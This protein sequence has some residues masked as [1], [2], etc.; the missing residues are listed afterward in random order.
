MIRWEERDSGLPSW[1]ELFQVVP[2]VWGANYSR[3]RTHLN[4]QQLGLF[5]A[6]GH[7]HGACALW[8]PKAI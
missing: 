5:Y 3:R 2:M 8:K 7:P 6:G 4:M 1:A